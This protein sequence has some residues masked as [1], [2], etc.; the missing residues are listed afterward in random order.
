MPLGNREGADSRLIRKSGDLCEAQISPSFRGRGVVKFLAEEV[1]F[2]KRF[3]AVG[4]MVL[5]CVLSLAFEIVDDLGRLVAIDNP[6][7]R[8]VIASPAITRYLEVLGV[9][10]RIVGVTDWDPYA[11]S[12][13]VEKI[14]NLVPLN[15]EKILSLG[16]DLV[17]ISGGFQEAEVA[18]LEKIGI[19][20]FVMNPNSFEDIYR[21]LMVVGNLFGI[22]DKGRITATNFRDEVLEIA[23]DSYNVPQSEKPKVV[24]IMIV[25][26]VSDIWTCGTGSFVNQAIAY[27]G[28]ANVGAPYSGNNGWFPVSPEFVLNSQPDIILVPYYYEGGQEEAV[29]MITSYKPF[30]DLPA[31]KNNRVYPLY[32]GLT[33]Y[34]NPDFVDLVKTLKEFFY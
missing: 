16:P 11:L 3:F 30:A 5:F 1:S 9:S 31:V 17:M 4:F 7:D 15:L 18:K 2:L 20:T 24:Y 19:S 27:A 13:E 26:E 34:A 14:G 33:A 6:P 21:N 12:N 32:D 29:K 8:V 23:K 10:S 28:G 25:G 22:P